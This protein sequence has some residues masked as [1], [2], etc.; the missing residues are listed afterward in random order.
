ML[1]VYTHPVFARHNTGF[2]HP[3]RAERLD[4]ALEGVSRA[5]LDDCVVYEPEAHPD[6]DRI[7]AK[8]HSA[9]YERDLEQA[10]RAGS[11]YFHS[12]DNPISSATFAAARAA[13]STALIAAQEQ[14]SF[15]IARPPGHHAERLTAM[16][17]CFFNTIACVAEWLREQPGIERVFIYDFDVHHGNGTQH[18]FE[19]RDDVYYA[20]IHRYPFYP[21]TGAA[22]EI[23]KGAGR[24]FTKNIPV[25]G[26][27]G[28]A[29]WLRATEEEIVP[30]IDDYRPNAILLSS[31]FDAHR[32]DPLGGMKVTEQAY[33]ELTR[34]IVEAAGDVRVLSLLEGGYDL[35]GLAA[36]VS[37]HVHALS[38][39]SLRTGSPTA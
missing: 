24:G 22:D 29:A 19:E 3:E 32:R 23:G 1:K 31:G 30:I 38:Q 33:G 8:V 37:E 26:G 34:R 14:R 11:R 27:E 4:A 5:G 17:F 15:V 35:E 25:R 2:D 6:T 39:Q 10:V 20:S 13:V 28:D 9:D 18:L 12:L 16:G 36:S 21:G 7:I